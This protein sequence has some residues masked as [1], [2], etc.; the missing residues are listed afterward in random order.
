[1]RCR[2]A[3]LLFPPGLT[4]PLMRAG[5]E[6]LMREPLKNLCVRVECELDQWLEQQAAAK[7]AATGFRRIGKSDVVRQYLEQARANT[8]QAA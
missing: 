4:L 1:L 5:T 3:S 2:R 6:V 7:R 8:E